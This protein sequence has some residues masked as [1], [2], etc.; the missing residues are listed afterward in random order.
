MARRGR[1]KGSD[2]AE[3]RQRIIGAARDDFATRGF[4]GASVSAIAATADLA[5]SAVYHYFGGKAALYEA[6]F[7]VTVDT[8]WANV[9]RAA[10]GLDTVVANVQA[11]IDESRN[12]RDDWPRHN[13]FLALV[14]METRLNPEFAHL[15][16]RRSKHQDETFGALAALGISTGE[17]DGFDVAGATEVIR[18]LIMG[19]FFERHF[20]GGEVAG[21]G[22]AVV[23]LFR[24]L[25]ERKRD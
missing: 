22:E 25:A 12:L 3:T 18:S 13:E 4:N 21:S 23:Q 19:W 10:S 2:S 15:L 14:P 5:P 9:G 6:V 11:I 16:D 17:L 8:I 7:V 1:P 20:R 24:L